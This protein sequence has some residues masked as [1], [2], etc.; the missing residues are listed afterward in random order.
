MT[1]NC[2]LWGESIPGLLA[3]LLKTAWVAPRLSQD[4]LEIRME[5]QENNCDAKADS[6]QISTGVEILLSMS[7]NT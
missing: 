4:V 1:T 5:A 2:N 3:S 6:G 7:H